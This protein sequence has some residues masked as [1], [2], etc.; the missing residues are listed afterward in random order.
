M[1][2][3]GTQP[4][5]VLV[6][7]VTVTDRR[8]SVQSR[9]QHGATG[10][11]CHIIRL[12]LHATPFDAKERPQD[13]NLKVHVQSSTVHHALRLNLVCGKGVPTSVCMLRVGKKE[14]RRNLRSA[15][16][17]SIGMMELIVASLA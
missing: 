12:A 1:S 10:L 13:V 11:Q 17:V 3:K 2:K 9:R 8:A 4:L 16:H 14:H 6:L 5:S 15:A 7:L